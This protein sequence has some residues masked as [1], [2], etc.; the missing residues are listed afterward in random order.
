VFLCVV[1]IVV[2]VADAAVVVVVGPQAIQLCW[3]SHREIFMDTSLVPDSW[4]AVKS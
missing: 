3:S 2:V 4:T 1:A